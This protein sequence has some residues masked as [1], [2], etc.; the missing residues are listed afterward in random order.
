M[1]II[2]ID[3]DAWPEIQAENSYNDPPTEGYRFV[4]WSMDVEN[5]R[6][7]VDEDERANESDFEMVGSRNVH[8]YT[9]RD[10]CGVIPDE[11][12]DDLYRGGKATGNVC[13]AVPIDETGLTFLYDALHDD[14]NGDS[15][16]VTVWF[17]ALPPVV[18]W[19]GLRVAPEDRCA[20]YDSNDYRYP[21]SVEDRI[22]EAL[23]GIYGPYTGRWFEST[24]ETDIEHMVARSEAHDS[25][26]CNIS[27]ARKKEFSKDLLNLTL[28]SPSVNRHQKSAKDA[29]DWLPDLNECW[30]LDR[31][32]QVREKYNLSIDQREADAIDAVLDGCSS[33]ALVYTDRPTPTP[34]P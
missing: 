24:S 8:Y 21:Q 4:M 31:V 14:E 9:F 28:A 3:L 26:M 22:V 10:S 33:V 15:F 11:L 12:N 19:R 25:G 18:Q 1:Q 27:D 16:R 32:V 2:D 13:L 30:F 34:S 7:S 5:V 6:G 29:A 20:A 23:G 17:K